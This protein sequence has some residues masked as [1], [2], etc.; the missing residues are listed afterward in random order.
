MARRQL[1]CKKQKLNNLRVTI[2]GSH[3]FEPTHHSLV[4]LF[5]EVKRQVA[6]IRVFAKHPMHHDELGSDV[7]HSLKLPHDVAWQPD[8]DII[9]AVGGGETAIKISKLLVQKI[10]LIVSFVGGADLTRQLCNL[11]LRLGY[12]R[13]FERVAVIT[14]PDRFG[15]QRLKDAGAPSAKMV[16]IPAALPLAHYKTSLRH[17]EMKVIMAGRPISRKNHALAIEISKQSKNLR[18][19]IIVGKKELSADNDPRIYQTDII[20]HAE[21]IRLLSTCDILLQTGN[22]NGTE[23]D[24]LPTIVL[25]AL[26]MG[27]PVISTPLVGVVELSHRFPDLIQIAETSTEF[28]KLLDHMLT[29]KKEGD[30]TKLKQ[31]IFQAHG[32][33]NIAN[34]ILDLYMEVV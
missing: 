29:S 30:I 26:A 8:A 33:K 2:V 31:W 16:C 4:G 12:Q 14:Y 24:S 34:Q 9:H 28:A 6:S 25:E 22:W 17:K 32:L 20:P 21:L 13:L 19:L 15:F 1:F 18:K 7:V 5:R 27:I 11:S 3:L 23:V 10:P